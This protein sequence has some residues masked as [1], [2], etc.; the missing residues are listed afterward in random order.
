MS[1]TDPDK[2]Y[3]H[4]VEKNHDDWKYSFEAQIGDVGNRHHI[5]I[6]GDN[7]QECLDEFK[8]AKAEALK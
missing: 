6:R 2:V 7:L 1:K 8:K 3:T 4:I 5:K